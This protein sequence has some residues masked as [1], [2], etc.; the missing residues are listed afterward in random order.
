MSRGAPPRYHTN[1]ISR[2]VVGGIGRV[3]IAERRVQLLLVLHAAPRHHA[4]TT[5]ARPGERR[6]G[7]DGG[8]EGEDH[9]AERKRVADDGEVHG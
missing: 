3:R 2:L 5:A 7:R 4:T 6:R 9:H 8:A 1:G